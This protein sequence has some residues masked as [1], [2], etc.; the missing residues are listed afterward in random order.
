MLQNAWLQ[1]VVV[2]YGKTW[3]NREKEVR[4][5]VQFAVEVENSRVSIFS[6]DNSVEVSL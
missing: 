3:W 4:Q 1:Y 6:A 5:Q 2:G